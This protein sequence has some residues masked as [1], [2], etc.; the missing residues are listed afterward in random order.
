MTTTNLLLPKKIANANKRFSKVCLCIIQLLN[1]RLLKVYFLEKY[2]LTICGQKLPCIFTLVLEK[3]LIFVSNIEAV[4]Y[5]IFQMNSHVFVSDFVEDYKCCTYK[6]IYLG[7]WNDVSVHMKWEQLNI[8]WIGIG[9]CS[10]DIY[11][12]QFVIFLTNLTHVLSCNY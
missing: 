8:C 7:I 11:K 12:F 9:V 10:Y 5:N 1:V 6:E 4:F 2:T 3:A